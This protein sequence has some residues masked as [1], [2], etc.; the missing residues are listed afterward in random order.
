MML[1]MI[2]QN[3]DVDSAV[4]QLLSEQGP[5]A[6]ALDRFE[7]RPQQVDMAC[8]VERS[9]RRSRHLV[10]EAGTGVG[11]SFAY[12]LPAIEHV[13]EQGGRAL[14]STY[15]IT[16][17]EQLVQK[18]IPVLE[19]NVGFQR[20]IGDH[21]GRNE[22]SLMLALRPNHT[23]LSLLRAGDY[24]FSWGREGTRARDAT[25]ELGRTT[26]DNVVSDIAAAMQQRTPPR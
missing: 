12:L 20:T 13:C 21:A 10:A 6:Q 25:L 16:L 8:A 2:M 1:I 24:S 9:F 4:R 26:V 19:F 15:T 22:T 11:K 14:I 23:D 5:I 17:Q 7:V 3:P 18:D